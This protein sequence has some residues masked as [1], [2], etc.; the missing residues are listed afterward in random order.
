MNKHL[1]TFNAE[2]TLDYDNDAN[3]FFYEWFTLEA[4][5]IDIKDLISEYFKE[6]DVRVKARKGAIFIV[7][8]GDKD[9]TENPEFPFNLNWLRSIGFENDLPNN[10]I[11]SISIPGGYITYNGKDFTLVNVGEHSEYYSPITIKTR[12]ELL[13]TLKVF[14]KIIL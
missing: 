1:W 8:K 13:T 2:G 9:D 4:G 6:G 11:L 5:G 12:E 10:L 7:Q 3:D 14:N